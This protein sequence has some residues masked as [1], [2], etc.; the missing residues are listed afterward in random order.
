MQMQTSS[1]PWWIRNSY[2][3]STAVPKQFEKFAG[4]EGVALVRAFANGSTDKGWG[5]NNRKGQPAFIPR[6][7]RGRFRES[8]VLKESTNAFAI[9]MRSVRL[10]CIDIDGK[11]GGIEHAKRL[12]MLPHTL[13]ETSKSGDGYHLFYSVDDEWDDEKGF[14]QL[15][16]RIGIVTGVDIRAVGCVYHYP[17]QRWNEMAIAPLP[18]HLKELLLHREQKLYDSQ[19]RINKI[20]DSDD[21]MEI[22]MLQDELITELNKPIDDGKRNNTLFA[23]GQKMKQAQV[24]GWETLLGARAEAVGLE[25]NEVVKLVGNISRYNA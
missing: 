13:A 2:T 21:E 5:L 1:T 11:N 20:L 16:D 8:A 23:I 10:V 18:D 7:T 24:P 3:V 9:V 12:G 22:L 6:Y 14:A 17:Q 4:P 19:A 25:T 15:S